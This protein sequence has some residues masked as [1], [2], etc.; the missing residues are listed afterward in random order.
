MF[1]FIVLEAKKLIVCNNLKYAVGRFLLI[2]GKS[3]PPPPAP[4]LPPLAAGAG[5]KGMLVLGDMLLKENPS[6]V[7]ST[8]LGDLRIII[9]NLHA[10]ILNLKKL[11]FSTVRRHRC[12]REKH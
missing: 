5:G 9:K 3:N 12:L 8:G 4:P 11:R 6:G 10:D 2:E 1:F 7:S